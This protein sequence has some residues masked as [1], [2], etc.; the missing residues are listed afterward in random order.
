MASSVLRSALA[1][2]ASGARTAASI[3]ART[4]ARFICYPSFLLS[5]LLT[6]DTRVAIHAMCAEEILLSRALT[7]RCCAFLRDVAAASRLPRN[8][9]LPSSAILGR[10][11]CVEPTLEVGGGSGKPPLLE[12]VSRHGAHRAHRD[13]LGPRQTAFEEPGVEGFRIGIML[14]RLDEEPTFERHPDGIGRGGALAAPAPSV[15]GIERREQRATHERRPQRR[16]GRSRSRARRRR[17]FAT[18]LIASGRLAL[19]RRYSFSSAAT[20]RTRVARSCSTTCAGGIGARV[21][22]V[23]RYPRQ[24]SQTSIFCRSRLSGDTREPRF[25]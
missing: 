8:N 24:P 19:G 15:G 18:M 22:I 17:G 3:S 2:P 20:S 10:G 16:H 6:A 1:T 11:A 23:L 12:H 7:R 21:V 5:P 13:R 14:D 4:M 25:P 9:R